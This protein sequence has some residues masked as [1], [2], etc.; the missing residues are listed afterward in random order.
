MNFPHISD[1]RSHSVWTTDYVVGRHFPS[2]PSTEILLKNLS[3]ALINDN[4]FLSH[5]IKYPPNFVT[6]LGLGLYRNEEPH[7]PS[8]HNFS[9]C[10]KSQ[11]IHCT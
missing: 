2:M 11:K 6:I 5:P 7:L 8:V 3:G 4:L 9:N 1:V 10:D